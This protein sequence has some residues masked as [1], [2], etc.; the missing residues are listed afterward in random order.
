MRPDARKSLAFIVGAVSLAVLFGG[1]APASETNGVTTA[2]RSST[3]TGDSSP[4]PAPPRATPSPPRPKSPRAQAASKRTAS[5]KP[6]GLGSIP[7]PPTPEKATGKPPANPQPSVEAK[8][9]RVR[10]ESGKTVIARLHGTDSEG[11]VSVMLPDGQLRI[12]ASRVATTDE[13]FRPATADE[14]KKELSD[15]PYAGFRIL[16]TK[17]YIV[18]YKSSPQFAKASGKLLEDLY[19]KLLEVLG[20]FGVATHE[21]EFPLVAV[22]YSTEKEFRANKRVAKEVQACYEIFPNHIFL[23]EANER[24]GAEVAALR[25]PQ[26]VAHEGTHQILA[27]IGVQPRL[28]EWPM[29][30]VEGLAE[31]CSPPVTVK[32]GHKEFVAW[33]GLG[34]VNPFHMATIRD[35]DDPRTLELE[36]GNGPK[37]GR[38]QGTPLVE[39]LVTKEDLTPTDYAL[40]WAVTHYLAQKRP[41]DFVEFLKQ[42]S[43]MRPL[44]KRTPKEHLADFRKA[45]GNDLARLDKAIDNYLAKLKY[46]PLPFYAVIFEQP[47]GGQRIQRRAMVS[48][49]P[50][51]IQ[52]WLESSVAPNGG[53]PRWEISP[54][55][56]RNTARFAI[57]Q[58]MHSR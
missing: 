42:M 50:S 26:T 13:P 35:L 5:R 24:D 12:A 30:L 37:L 6:V 54:Y 45:F 32:K 7:P 9:I 11:N 10:T 21:T 52:Q 25:R 2:G 57:E 22:I 29:W 40:A 43:Q 55:A 1:R 28:S 19:T 49:S 23:Y 33:N 47:I 58:W 46:D 44:E 14:M 8:R 3:G 15:G 34:K 27:N 56:S 20:K 48:Q 18:F 31:Y 4:P 51:M 17:H 16:Q 38:R 41:S 39:Y 36:G 53:E